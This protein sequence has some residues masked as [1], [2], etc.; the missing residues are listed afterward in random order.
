MA[1]KQKNNQQVLKWHLSSPNFLS[2]LLEKKQ[3]QKDF[4]KK[5]NQKDFALIIVQDYIMYMEF[6]P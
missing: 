2:K 3:N 1:K 5:Q 6:K 4:A